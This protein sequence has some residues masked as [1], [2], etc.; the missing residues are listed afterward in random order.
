MEM[1]KNS[2]TD[3]S[4]KKL[5]LWWQLH[6]EKKAREKLAEMD[7][8]GLAEKGKYVLSLCEN[9]APE[10]D[11]D[12]EPLVHRLPVKDIHTLWVDKDNWDLADGVRQQATAY[13]NELCD[14]AKTVVAAYYKTAI[15]GRLMPGIEVLPL[16][17]VFPHYSATTMGWRMGI[18]EVYEAVYTSMLDNMDT[19]ER[20]RYQSK[21]PAPEYMKYRCHYR[22]ENTAAY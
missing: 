8:A 22:F 19:A 16:W 18:G 1:L 11:P 2:T 15:D 7:M 20:S 13:V 14:Y 3:N 5:S 21:Y 10:T 12:I 17:L 6:G 4:D 9:I